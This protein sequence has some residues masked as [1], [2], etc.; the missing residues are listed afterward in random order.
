MAIMFSITPPCVIS[1]NY[2][3]LSECAECVIIISRFLLVNFR[4]QPAIYAAC[5]P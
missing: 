4:R 1:G 3:G 5:V 2:L